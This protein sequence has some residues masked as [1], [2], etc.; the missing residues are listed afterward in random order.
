MLFILICLTNPVVFF[1][2]TNPSDAPLSLFYSQLDYFILTK[3][4]IFYQ[5][6]FLV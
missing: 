3:K 4:I 6:Y 5:Q 1:D 2:N